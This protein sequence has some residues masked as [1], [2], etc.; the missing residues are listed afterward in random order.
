MWPKSVV[1]IFAAMPFFAQAQKGPSLPA[2]Q[3]DIV[4]ATPIEVASIRPSDPASCGEYPIVDGHNDRFDMKCVK[5]NLLLEMA[6]SVREFQIA[7]GPK[8]IGSTQ[9]DIAVKTEFSPNGN[10]GPGKDVAQLT[11]EERRANGQ[12][13]REILRALLADRFRVTVHNETREQTVLLLKIAR[14]GPKLKEISSDVS[15]GL[16]PGRGFLAGTQVRI[17]FLAQT[18]SQIVG[19]PILDQTGLTGKYDFEL[20]WTPDQSSPN[21]A[22]GET[23]TPQAPADPDRPNIFTALQEQIGLKL[24]S[25]KGPVALIVVDHIERPSPN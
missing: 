25:G 16:R 1:A 23:L 7:G 22:L 14:G 12:R 3:P 13:M 15:G 5:A 4:A 24:E 17:P 21:S 18:L 11:D 2:S 19:Q 8:W 20:R 9:Y 6:Y 10:T